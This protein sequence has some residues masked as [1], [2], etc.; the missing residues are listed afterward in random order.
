M[1]TTLAGAACIGAFLGF[2][3]VAAQDAGPLGAATEPLWEV[4]V[5]GFAAVGPQ[6]PASSEYDVNG[7][8]IPF[9]IYRGDF[10]RVDEGSARLVPLD[11]D[12]VEI[13]LSLNAS[14]GADSDDNEAREGMPD[15][16]TLVE[17]GPELILKGPALGI[18]ES[19]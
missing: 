6:Y 19:V 10:F 11:T 8:P 5:G 18:P 15:L 17:F 7:L 14:F 4:G 1:R 3:P 12:T 2:G 9:F 16:D 13:D